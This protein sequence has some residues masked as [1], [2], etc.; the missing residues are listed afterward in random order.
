MGAV[1]ECETL[2]REITPY[3]SGTTLIVLRGQSST[4]WELALRHS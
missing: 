1:R 2:A 3:L 4:F